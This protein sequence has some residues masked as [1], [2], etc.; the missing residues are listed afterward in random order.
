MTRPLKT[1]LYKHRDNPYPTKAEKMG[2]AADSNMTLTQVSNWF[3]NARRR[4]KNTVS[5]PDLSWGKRVQMYNSCVKGNQ[6]LLSVSSEDS[7]WES[8]E[9]TEPKIQHDMSSDGLQTRLAPVTCYATQDQASSGPLSPS[10]IPLN[11]SRQATTS[12]VHQCNRSL[13][14]AHQVITE[15]AQDRTSFF[16]TP[17][18]QRTQQLQQTPP[19]EQDMEQDT[20]QDTPRNMQQSCDPDCGQHGVMPAEVEQPPK[21]K[22]SILQ[23]YLQDSYQHN[24]QVNQPFMHSTRHRNPSGSLSSHDYE[25]L[26]VSSR[27]TP[28]RDHD[29]HT[30]VPLAVL[31]PHAEQH[32]RQWSAAD[33]E[34]EDLHWKEISAA[35]ALT[36]LS[37]GEFHTSPLPDQHKL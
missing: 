36:A 14:S 19:H 3:A 2:L 27:S 8:G 25:D 12:P 23:R 13:E 31:A 17:N 34:S 35:L 22:N 10:M 26:S 1:W 29:N 28:T 9:E 20:P 4:L 16:R 37:R 30:A 6:E 32:D 7:A 33:K 18:R 15:T 21:F 5:N 11:L 24:I